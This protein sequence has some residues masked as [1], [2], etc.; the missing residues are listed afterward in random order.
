MGPPAPPLKET[1][2]EQLI[3][4]TAEAE[5]ALEAELVYMLELGN[6]SRSD[7][8]AVA[9]KHGIKANLKSEVIIEEICQQ[10]D[11][12]ESAEVTRLVDVVRGGQDGI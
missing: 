12:L 1:E 10:R 7:L 3:R 4:E 8:Q 9:K 5:A 11:K 6:M 2:E